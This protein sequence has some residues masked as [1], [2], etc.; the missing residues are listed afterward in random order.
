M[1]HKHTPMREHC[2]ARMPSR[3]RMSGRAGV[4]ASQHL[5][6]PERRRGVCS[7]LERVTSAATPQRAASKSKRRRRGVETWVF[8]N[9]YFMAAPFSSTRRVR[10]FGRAGFAGESS[11]T[12][13]GVTSGWG[14]RR[15]ARDGRTNPVGFVN[16]VVANLQGNPGLVVSGSS[17][18]TWHGGGQRE[19]DSSGCVSVCQ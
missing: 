10:K 17:A 19:S 8:A 14:A 5:S 1:G 11:R 12:R 18:A 9:A 4:A 13:R 6:R 2:C 7:R 15:R 16:S 3:R